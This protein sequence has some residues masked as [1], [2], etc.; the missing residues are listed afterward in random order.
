ML[1]GRR[2]W[3]YKVTVPIEQIKPTR[4]AKATPRD[5]NPLRRTFVRQFGGVTLLPSSAGYGLRDPDHPEQEPESNLQRL[6]RRP[7]AAR[8]CRRPVFS[9]ATHGVAGRA[10]RGGDPRRA[11]S[12]LDSL[13]GTASCN[14]AAP[15]QTR[16]AA[17]SLNGTNCL[18]DTLQVLF[19]DFRITRDRKTKGRGVSVP[20]PECHGASSG[21]FTRP[22]GRPLDW[23]FYYTITDANGQEQRPGSSHSDARALPPSER[24]ESVTLVSVGPD[25]TAGSSGS[26]F[27]AT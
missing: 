13:N 17:N 24:L 16:H 11:A 8:C 4:Q 21:G 9:R 12:G 7:G 2:V 22:R 14:R 6:L 18:P 26:F 15:D 19:H 20:R 25:R 10:R 3:R 27:G 1:P 23:Y 5:E